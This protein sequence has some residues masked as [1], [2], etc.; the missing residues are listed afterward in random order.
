MVIKDERN[1][2]KRKIIIRKIR[3]TCKESGRKSLHQRKKEFVKREKKKGPALKYRQQK[4]SVS[5]VFTFYGSLYERFI[6]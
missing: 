5:K 4:N 1:S 2:M 6:V 3:E